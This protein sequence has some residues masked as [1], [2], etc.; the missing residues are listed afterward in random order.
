MELMV[1]KEFH[2]AHSI[3]GHPL[4]GRLHGHAY[5]VLFIFEVLVSMDSSGITVDFG[6]LNK[7]LNEVL[8]QLDHRN[9]NEVLGGSASVERLVYYLKE[10]VEKMLREVQLL[11]GKLRLSEIQVWETRNYGVRLCLRS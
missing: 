6:L 10:Q 4:C 7:E 1:K 5:E 11:K 2:S 9:L 3:E 8:K